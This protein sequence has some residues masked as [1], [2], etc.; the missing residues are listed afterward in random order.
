MNHNAATREEERK[1]IQR[2]REVDRSRRDR[3]RR[4]IWVKGRHD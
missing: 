3:K 1:R 2:I 4:D